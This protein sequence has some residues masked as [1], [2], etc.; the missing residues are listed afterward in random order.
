MRLLSWND[1][2][3][4]IFCSIFMP[5]VEKYGTEKLHDKPVLHSGLGALHIALKSISFGHLGC[6][7]WKDYSLA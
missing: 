1:L 6:A 5:T 3:I 7:G 2:S 4:K